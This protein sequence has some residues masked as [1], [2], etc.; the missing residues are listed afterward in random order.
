MK[1]AALAMA[2]LFVLLLLGTVVFA[3]LPL[4]SNAWQQRQAESGD[5]FIDS[6]A[7]SIRYLDLGPRR[8]ETVILIHSFNGFIESWREQTATL[9]AAGYRVI[10][11]DLY[12]RGLSDLPDG[13]LSLSVFTGQLSE[14]MEAVG[15]HRAH[16]VGGSFGAVIAAEFSQTYPEQV[17]S[18]SFVGP[19]GWPTEGD[20]GSQALI[21][22]P[23]IGELLFHYFGDR[24]IE[25]SVDAYFVDAKVVP[26][27]KQLWLHYAETGQFRRASLNILRHSP[28]RDYSAGWQKLADSHHPI[29]FL[30]GDKDVSFPVD[31]LDKVRR[32]IPQAEISVIPNTAHWLNI[33]SP[34]TVNARL[35][36]F[37][38]S[39]FEPG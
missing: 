19:A 31:N 39:S 3:Y 28:V 23:V 13:P 24:L 30:W 8:A 34:K 25:P 26:W 29:L 22:T 9:E 33:E 16:L 15:V 20:A 7:G 2:G 4:D 35:L 27:A 14:L 18:L 1:K 10:A 11:Y 36:A 12:G 6:S 32:W 37:L 38:K 5:A 21:N 17:Q